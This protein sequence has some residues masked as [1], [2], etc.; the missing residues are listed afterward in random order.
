MDSISEISYKDLHKNWSTDLDKLHI[1]KKAAGN[2]PIYK[3]PKLISYAKSLE[4]DVDTILMSC[5][6]Y[7]ILDRFF[8]LNNAE[9]KGISKSQFTIGKHTD[10]RVIPRGFQQSDK[11]NGLIMYIMYNSHGTSIDSKVLVCHAGG[12]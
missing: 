12:K 11:G 8:M 4:I 2:V 9:I 7:E 5:D 3:L 10:I 1:I 6:I